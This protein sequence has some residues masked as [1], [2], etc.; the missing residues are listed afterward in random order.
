M[1]EDAGTT[2]VGDEAPEGEV[3]QTEPQGTPAGVDE[4]T[5][6]RSRQAGLD[7]TVS[8]LR[9]EKEALE[10]RAAAAEARAR[11]LAEGQTASNDEITTMLAQFKEKAEAAEAKAEA[12]ELAAKFPETFREMGE[13]I[14]SL[15]D[16]RLESIEARLAGIAAESVGEP[17]KPVANA[18]A[19]TPAAAATNP[20]GMSL[21]DYRTWFK[22]K[23]GNLTGADLVQTE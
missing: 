1:T 11:E 17:P 19:R 7:R 18:Q 23:F 8:T 4:V 16:D 9:A 12:L 10:A 2:P 6:L 3:E 20:E 14:V 22:S 15:S 13:A 21:E 5:T